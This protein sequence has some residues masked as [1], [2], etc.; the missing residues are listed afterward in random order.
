L[1]S[2]DLLLLIGHSVTIHLLLTEGAGHTGRH[3]RD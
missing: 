1:N 2:E 3:N